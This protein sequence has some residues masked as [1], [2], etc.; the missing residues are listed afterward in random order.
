VKARKSLTAL[1]T[2]PRSAPLD[3]IELAEKTLRLVKKH[4]R[5]RNLKL[6]EVTKDE[7]TIRA[8]ATM[9]DFCPVCQK[10]VPGDPDVVSA[11]VDACILHASVSQEELQTGHGEQW[12]TY[13][14]G[15]ETRIRLT[16]ITGYQGWQTTTFD[17]HI[18]SN[19]FC[20]EKVPALMFATPRN[21]MSTTTLTL[22]VKMNSCL[23]LLSFAK[24]MCCH[25][26]K[27][28]NKRTREA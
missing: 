23:A 17:F 11:H 12:D 25:W 3:T 14:V 15:G 9:E 2:G 19:V 22:T 16:S 10:H 7:V 18:I 4:R 20:Y 27:K 21:A 5:E 28:M 13:E 8:S 24:A 1:N 26:V 6:R